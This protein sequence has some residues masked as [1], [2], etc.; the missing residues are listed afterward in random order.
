MQH[1]RPLLRAQ[2][3]KVGQLLE[4]PDLAAPPRRFRVAAF[5]GAVERGELA[6]DACAFH[7]QPPH[8]AQ[9]V[10]PERIRRVARALATRRHHERTATHAHLGLERAHQRTRAHTGLTDHRHHAAHAA[11]RVVEHVGELRELFGPAHEPPDLER[12]AAS[13]QRE[14][15]AVLP[16]HGARR[17]RRAQQRVHRLAMRRR[18]RHA[19]R[20]RQAQ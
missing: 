12:L 16:R 19:D 4:Q 14:R 7:G 20:Q 8:R 13:R 11:H 6:P 18:A 3:E 1:Q 17:A 10:T 15:E 5:D 9:H 2:A